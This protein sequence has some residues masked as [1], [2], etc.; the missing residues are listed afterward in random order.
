MTYW[1]GLL[2]AV[3]AFSRMTEHLQMKPGGVKRDQ[4]FLKK[5]NCI[6]PLISVDKKGTHLL[7][8]LWNQRVGQLI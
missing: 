2:G 6:N 8:T 3:A 7:T 4:V 1:A 5:S